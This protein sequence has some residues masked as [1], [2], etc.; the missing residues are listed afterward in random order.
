MFDYSNLLRD[1]M[2]IK[3]ASKRAARQ[4]SSSTPDDIFR[5][6]YNESPFGPSPKAMEVLTNACK[7]SYE[8]PDWFSIELKKNIVS[9]YGL[10][11]SNIVTGSG[12]SALIC[13]LGEIFINK[14]DEF[15]IGDPSYEA[16]RDVAYDYG[17]APILV[18]LTENLDYDLDAM[19]RAVTPKTKMLIICNPNNPTGAFV[20]SEKLEEFIKK[21]PE[22][23]I[24][25]IDEAYLEYVT[26][27]N[28]YSMVKLIKANYAKPLIVLKTFSKIYGMAGLRIGYAVTSPDL[29]D[30]MCKS[31]HAWNVSRIGQLAASAAITDQEYIHNIR[32]VIAK[33]RIKVSNALKDMGCKV[34][35]SQANFI[36]FKCSVDS[37]E[38]SSKLAEDKILIGAPCGYNRV[39][40]ALPGMNDKF[41]SCMKK[42]LSK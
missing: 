12:A 38:V 28:T 7:K 10:D 17:A 40:L 6:N 29:A 34:Y 23:V 2:K 42:I 19:L 5:M 36:L 37:L 8:Y 26:K 27:E 25:V 9:F 4:K 39:S 1:S 15:I 13:M 21:I 30:C 41:I 35:E 18:P 31:S 33:E 3:P 11:I 14:G 32:D 22:H 24:T 16:F 20:D